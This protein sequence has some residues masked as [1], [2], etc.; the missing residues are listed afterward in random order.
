VIETNAF[1]AS[2]EYEGVTDDERAAIVAYITEDPA[3]GDLIKDTG[4][5]RKVR[6][7]GKGRQVRRIQDHHLLRRLGRA[8]LPA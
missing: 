7:A 4:G 1:L 6:F 2:A 8:S 3:R 5:A